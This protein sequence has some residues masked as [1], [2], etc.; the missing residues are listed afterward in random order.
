MMSSELLPMTVSRSSRAPS[1]HVAT[2]GRE[3]QCSKTAHGRRTSYA[4][5]LSRFGVTRITKTARLPPSPGAF[6]MGSRRD[7]PRVVLCVLC[8]SA[9]H[10]PSWSGAHPRLA[11]P[12]LLLSRCG[13]R[14]DAHDGPIVTSHDHAGRAPRRVGR[15]HDES[16]RIPDL[17]ASDNLAELGP[18]SWW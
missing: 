6:R 9:V 2:S 16:Q 15:L 12:A 4:S 8:G 5:A 13:E 17:R 14:G 7:V 18:R 1:N 11:Q 10:G 3:G